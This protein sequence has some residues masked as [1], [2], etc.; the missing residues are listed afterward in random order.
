MTTTPATFHPFP[1]LPTELRLQIWE[2]SIE[3]QIQQPVIT[4]RVAA[5]GWRLTRVPPPP[6]VLY[7]NRESRNATLK[8]P[9]LRSFRIGPDSS[10][11]YIHFS[12]QTTILELEIATDD[13]HSKCHD[14]DQCIT[15]RRIEDVL[16][17]A[18][19]ATETLHL[20]RRKI[21]DG[22]ELGGEAHRL[23]PYGGA[24]TLPTSS[25]GV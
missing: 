20:R 13:E 4:V 9:S 2:S 17:D 16:R 12:P 15:W 18:L 21:V 25:R 8:N 5:K 7:T 1:R 11:A 14:A 3:N 19:S 6:G 24:A 10:P 23:A 22:T